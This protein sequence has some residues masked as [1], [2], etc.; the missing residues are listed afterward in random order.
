MNS[1]DTSKITGSSDTNDAGMWSLLKSKGPVKQTTPQHTFAPKFQAKGPR[2]SCCGTVKSVVSKTATVGGILGAGYKLL[3]PFSY[4]KLG[5]IALSGLSYAGYAGAKYIAA[6]SILPSWSM[7]TKES[8]A[9]RKELRELCIKVTKQREKYYCKEIEIKTEDG[10]DLDAFVIQPWKQKKNRDCWVINF[11]G[12]GT[13]YEDAQIIVN[14]Q[15]FNTSG[16]TQCNTFPLKCI[17][18]L[19][20]TGLFFN[21]RGMGKDGKKKFPTKE[22]LMKDFAAVLQY[23]KAQGAKKIIINGRSLGGAVS[24]VGWENYKANYASKDD[25]DI[26][27]IFVNNRS[28]TN[29]TDFVPAPISWAVKLLG[30]ELNALKVAKNLKHHLIV[31]YHDRDD[32]IVEKAQLWKALYKAKAEA[33][34]TFIQLTAPWQSEH[35]EGFYHCFPLDKDDLNKMIHVVKSKLNLE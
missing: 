2:K 26:K 34:K 20:A 31:A 6:T 27:Y 33:N 12:N 18:K 8:I 9:S 28:L 4:I 7:D 25:K 16:K 23:A 21:Y 13:S 5:G 22:G 29:T 32:V 30:W 14:K 19:G 3:S 35:E 10:V 24:L 11:N 17:N 1:L 15:F